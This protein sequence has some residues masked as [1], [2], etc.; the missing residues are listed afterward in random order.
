MSCRPPRSIPPYPSFP[1]PPS[2]PPTRPRPIPLRRSSPPRLA[3]RLDYAL[4]AAVLQLTL[5]IST[6]LLHVPVALG[7]AHQGGA[8][9]L[10]VTVILAWHADGLAAEAADRA[11]ERTMPPN[12][13]P[14]RVEAR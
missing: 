1:P 7:V 5:G 4:A 13:H 9:L 2:F 14:A 10:L 3:R 8:A 12:W 11:A 6:L